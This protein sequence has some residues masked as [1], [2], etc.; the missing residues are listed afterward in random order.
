MEVLIN[1]FASLHGCA[2]G[3]ARSGQDWKGA[4]NIGRCR[5]TSTVV[6]AAG[7][8]MLTAGLGRWPADHAALPTDD[9]D[10][11]SHGTRSPTEFVAGPLIWRQAAQ[12]MWTLDAMR[13]P[14][15][16]AT[17]RPFRKPVSAFCGMRRIAGQM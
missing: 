10:G 3:Q 12:T 14:S 6:R 1:F 2:R 11:A 7:G 5:G 9:V 4:G 16:A 15:P 17:R 13:R 8:W